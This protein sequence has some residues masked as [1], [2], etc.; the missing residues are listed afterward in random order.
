MA[1]LIFDGAQVL[2]LL[3]HAKASTQHSALYSEKPNPGPG[4]FLV[5]DDGIYLMSNGQ[6]IQPRENGDSGAKV[7]YAKGYEPP[8]MVKDEDR[9]DQYS[10]IV[11]AAGGDDFAE[12][13]GADVFESRNPDVVISEVRIT[14]EA[15]AITVDLMAKPDPS[16]G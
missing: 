4:L 12:L 9:D 16:K 14:L 11:A 10:K 15:D 2:K 5:K 13:L 6:A 8:R 3:A 1:Q 7:V